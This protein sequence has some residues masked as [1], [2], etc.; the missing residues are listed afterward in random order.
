[1]KNNIISQLAEFS[2]DLADI[3][4]Y[5]SIAQ[6]AMDFIENNFDPV[7]WS[8]MLFDAHDFSFKE[9][10][11][12]GVR[13]SRTVDPYIKLSGDVNA[14]I[15]QGGE[16]LVLPDKNAFQFLMLFDQDLYNTCELRFPFSIGEKYL[17]VLNLG[18]KQSGTD[19]TVQDIDVFRILVNLVSNACLNCFETL[20]RDEVR[21]VPKTKSFST[22]CYKVKNR[23]SDFDLLGS[24]EA[25]LKINQL[26]DR[27]AVEEVPVLITGESGTGKELVARSIHMKSGRNQKQLVAM[28]CAALPDSLVESELFGH[29]KGAFTGAFAQKKGKFEYAHQSTLFLDEI[30]DMSLPTQAKLLRVLNDGHFQRVGGNHSMFSDARVIAATNKDLRT[31][32]KEGDFREDL[33]YRINV[34]QINIPPLRDR[35]DDVIMLSEHFFH[36][37]NKQYQRKL[38][39]FDKTVVDWLLGYE[40]PGNVRE[41]KNIIERAV[42]MET[43]NKITLEQMPHRDVV[44]KDRSDTPQSKLADLEREH[45]LA[46]MQQVDHNK[47]AAA[48]ILG[49]ARKTLREKLAK[50]N[51]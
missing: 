24:S 42:I 32:M 35:N 5:K 34:F 49:I 33:F 11:F 23:S 9:E 46:V 37:F 45:I 21:T 39:G 25:I 14:S 36:F 22:C 18:P 27:V 26:I 48:R 30:G 7:V 4:N 29:E 50:Y 41:L 10:Q 38:A 28:N 8:L 1:M 13:F 51:I 44:Q 31:S 3:K 20:D 43:H 47:S 6:K 17:G 15:A 12:R 16:V 40:F 19:F 2:E